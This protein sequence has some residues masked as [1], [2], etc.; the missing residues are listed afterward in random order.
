VLRR[1]SAPM[2]I[3]IRTVSP[4]SFI[5]AEQRQTDCVPQDSET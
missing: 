3:I 4:S 2:C 5:G 1:I